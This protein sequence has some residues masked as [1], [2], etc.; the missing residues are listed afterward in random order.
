[1]KRR[2]KGVKHTSKSNVGDLI[3]SKDNLIY[4]DNIT[5]T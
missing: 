2:A 1:M 5:P 3:Q 4:N